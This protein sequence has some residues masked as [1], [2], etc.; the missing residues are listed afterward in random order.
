M[1]KIAVIVPVYNIE[2]YLS[3]CI[4]SILGQT[5]NDFRL[6]LVN[7]G[8]TDRSG[9]ICDE[10]KE[11]DSRIKVIHQENMGLSMARNNGIQNSKEDYITFIDSD[12]YVHK[13]MLKILYRNLKKYKGDIS[14]C[15]FKL[16]YED[17]KIEDEES[18]NHSFARNNRQAVDMIVGGSD[19]GMI[20]AWGKVY[21]RSLFEN[22]KYPKGKYHEDEFVTYKLLY[23]AKRVVINTQELYY[24]TQR[25]QSITG[26]PYS[27][28]RLEKLEAL[29]EAIDFFKELN[30]KELETRA[31]IR[32][33]M[34]IQIGYYKV[35]YEMS[36][37][38]DTLKKLKSE[39]DLNYKYT[40]KNKYKL[41]IRNKIMLTFFKLSPNLY[42]YVVKK[43]IK[44]GKKVK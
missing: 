14:V 18:E 19:V 8:S 11:K 16:S 44:A 4:D 40:M 20:V 29:K 23:N 25:K 1:A 24:Y 43:S 33:L 35:R 34:N 21:K 38:Q 9:D 13:D 17:E 41:T 22:T 26:E 10:Y 27:L 39:Y 31:R 15:Q 28:K 3:R 5:F 36:D 42:C 37:Q 12:D 7:D 6:I 2:E 32:Y 30:E